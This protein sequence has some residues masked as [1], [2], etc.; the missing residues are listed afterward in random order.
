MALKLLRFL[1]NFDYGEMLSELRGAS[2]ND[3]S[4]PNPSFPPRTA[5]LASTPCSM[6]IPVCV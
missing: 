4:P 6:Y 1:D 2:E 3:C 5:R